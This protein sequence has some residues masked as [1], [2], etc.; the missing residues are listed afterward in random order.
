MSSSKKPQQ[1]S[2]LYSKMLITRKVPLPITNIGSNTHKTITKIITRQMEGKCSVEGYI[3]PNSILVQ[4]YSSGE[5]QGANVMFDAV[6]EC[7]VCCPVEGMEISCV[8]KNI[9]KAGIRAEID[10]QPTPVVIFLARDHH[11]SAH[12]SNVKVNERINVRVIG[13][14]F[15]L[16]DKYVSIIAELVEPDRKPK[17][18]IGE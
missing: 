16:N 3:R 13:Q 5:L 6:I 1:N 14:C 2:D 8:A 17:L 10:E 11:S 15:E 7:D 4:D 18:K 9:T 12:F